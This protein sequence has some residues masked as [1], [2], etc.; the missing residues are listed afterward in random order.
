MLVDLWEVIEPE[1]VTVQIERKTG[2]GYND[3]GEWTGEVITPTDIQAVVQPATG[4]KLND[5]PEGERASAEYFLW[6]NEALVL[7][8][9]IIYGG[10]RYRITSVWPRP[11]GGFYRA[12]LGKM[13]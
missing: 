4:A 12:V 2:G 13:R 11:E 6:S 8:D 10:S 5:L 1:A 7:D 3:D 9:V